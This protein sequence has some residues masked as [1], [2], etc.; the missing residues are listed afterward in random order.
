MDA[1]TAKK[2]AAALRSGKFKQE[3]GTLVCGD[4]TKRC[5][6]GVLADVLPPER[7]QLRDV[8]KMILYTDEGREWGETG[9]SRQQD[10]SLPIPLDILDEEQQTAFITMNDSKNLSFEK[11]ADEVELRFVQD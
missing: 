1:E 5:C 9:I 6:L 4:G 11:I 10:E 3:H 8:N 2:W 7:A